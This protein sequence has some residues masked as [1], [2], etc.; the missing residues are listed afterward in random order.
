MCVVPI[1]RA[2][3]NFPVC[4]Q[5]PSLRVSLLNAASDRTLGPAPPSLFSLPP[6]LQRPAVRQAHIVPPLCLRFGEAAA[7]WLF[8]W[9]TRPA[10][11]L[12]RPSPSLPL[13]RGIP[14]F[15]PSF[16]T[17]PPVIA[18][19]GPGGSGDRG[20]N[21]GGGFALEMRKSHV[22]GEGKGR[23]CSFWTHWSFSAIKDSS[24]EW[25][26]VGGSIEGVAG[27]ERPVALS[28]S[29]PARAGGG[30][31]TAGNVRHHFDTLFEGGRGGGRG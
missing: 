16:F 3:A 21:R 28:S 1:R 17:E 24:R 25:K 8:G 4:P 18:F 2:P 29:R 10:L 27:R 22:L 19:L 13:P 20:L 30:R 14:P 5:G 31:R 9:Y 26:P 6:P 12:P 11:P 15:E 23:R 7:A